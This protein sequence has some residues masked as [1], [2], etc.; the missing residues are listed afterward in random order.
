MPVKLEGSC[1]CGT[2]RFSVLS[3]TPVPYQ[4]GF[5]L[6][7]KEHIGVYRAVMN[8]DT[9]D[10]SIASSERNFCTKCSSMLWL[11]DENWYVSISALPR[12]PELL[13]PFASA[14]D[15]PELEA[16]GEMV[17]IFFVSVIVK[18]DSKPDYVRLPEGPKKKYE[19]YGPH[20]IE[21]WHKK[22]RKYVE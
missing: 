14:I 15:S 12:S 5:Y 17:C 3:S 21:E 8:R 2:V 10:E 4:V 9:P 13:H 20:S 16:A 11:Y 6:F 18:L 19:H 7:R 1:H 22:H